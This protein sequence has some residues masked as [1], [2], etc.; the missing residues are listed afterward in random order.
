GRPSLCKFK[1]NRAR[2]ALTRSPF[3]ITR[4]GSWESIAGETMSSE[5]NVLVSVVTPVFN[6]ERYLRECIESVLAQTYT[7]WDYVIVDNQS[8]DR[9]NEIAHEYAAR[10]PRIRVIRNDAFVRVVQNY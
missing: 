1:E 6:G 10:D 8:T 2:S 7:N 3:F 9:T 4:T 5:Q